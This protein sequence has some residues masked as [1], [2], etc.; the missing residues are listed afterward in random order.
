[1]GYFSTLYP[2]RRFNT[3]KKRIRPSVVV[4]ML[5]RVWIG[6]QMAQFFKHATTNYQWSDVTWDVG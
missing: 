3:K 2:S 5:P 6:R 1:M 4:V